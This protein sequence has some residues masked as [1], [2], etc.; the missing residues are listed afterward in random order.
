MPKGVKIYNKDLKKN[1]NK[2]LPSHTVAVIKSTNFHGD[3]VL[4]ELAITNQNVVTFT[5]SSSASKITLT[6]ISN[7]ER[8]AKRSID[9]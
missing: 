4:S 1:E 3:L 5:R 8:D 2:S 6:Q 9:F 7:F